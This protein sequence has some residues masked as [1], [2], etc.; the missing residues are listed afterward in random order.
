MD[1]LVG[2]A[3]ASQGIFHMKGAKQRIQPCMHI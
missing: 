2:Q 1:D 3:G